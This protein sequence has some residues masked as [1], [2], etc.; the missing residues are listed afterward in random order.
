MS[1]Q[2]TSLKNWKLIMIPANFMSLWLVSF[3]ISEAG[4]M[5]DR[6]AQNGK[7]LGG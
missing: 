6:A 2:G 4:A 7:W 5:A 1:R 3:V